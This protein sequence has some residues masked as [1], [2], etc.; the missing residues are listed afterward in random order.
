[1]MN[2]TFKLIVL[3]VTLT[4]WVNITTAAEDY[5]KKYAG[6]IPVKVHYTNS[7]STRPMNLRGLDSAKGIIYAEMEGAGSLELELRNLPRQNI[8][9]FELSNSPAPK[10]TIF[11]IYSFSDSL[12]S[13][14]P[15]CV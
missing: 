11:S 10:L 5:F 3:F 12:T 13:F 4:G 15:E 1:M 6:V 8:K 2:K 14:V 7:A 9:K